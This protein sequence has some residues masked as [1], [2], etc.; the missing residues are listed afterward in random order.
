MFPLL[1]A[2]LEKLKDK[3]RQISNVAIYNTHRISVKCWTKILGFRDV[4]NTLKSENPQI[5]IT[6]FE[7]PRL[8]F[9]VL[10]TLEAKYRLSTTRDG[11]Q[12]I[13]TPA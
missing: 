10:E 5:N 12:R 11:P 8:V 6:I 2:E 3:I 7:P 9:V 13:E 1:P 4:Y